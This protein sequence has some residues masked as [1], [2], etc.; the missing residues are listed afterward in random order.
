MAADWARENYDVKQIIPPPTGYKV[1]IV[2]SGPAGLTAAGEL[3]K[4]GH[5]LSCI[6]YTERHCSNI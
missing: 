6:S 2:G 4:M 5:D 1:A 3:A